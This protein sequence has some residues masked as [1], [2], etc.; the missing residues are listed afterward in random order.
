MDENIR[1]QASDEI[2]E[3]TQIYHIEIEDSGIGINSV[4]L[5]KIFSP[6]YSKFAH[7]EYPRHGLGLS[8]VYDIIVRR[9]EG[10]IA[11]ESQPNQGT[12]IHLYLPANKITHPGETEEISEL[13]KKSLGKILFIDDEVQLL[14]LFTK[15]LERNGYSVITAEN[16]KKGL[17]ILQNLEEPID[18][19]V[20]DMAMPEMDGKQF[21]EQLPERF[22][23]IKIIISSGSRE[24]T[25]DLRKFP[26][27]IRFLKK[28][29]SIEELI[30]VID[31]LIQKKA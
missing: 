14:H 18:L 10:D 31:N 2:R 3:N 25:E 24:K 19:I 15:G 13:K 23:Q 22:H 6:F 11:V 9:Y 1:I 26:F 5:T 8:I 27:S 30:T 20:L 16:G 21:L 28:P 29:Y 12:K 4:D 7:G 17:Q